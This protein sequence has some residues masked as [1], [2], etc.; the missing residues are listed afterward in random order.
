MA[1]LQASACSPHPH[2]GNAAMI[3]SSLPSLMACCIAAVLLL[4]ALLG[5]VGDEATAVMIVK[6]R[7]F[8]KIFIGKE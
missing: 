8:I 5:S 3:R 7:T 2:D 4:V 1:G 6:T